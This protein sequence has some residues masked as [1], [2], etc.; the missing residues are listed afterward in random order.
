MIP[1]NFLQHF[2]LNYIEHSYS[3]LVENLYVHKTKT[4]DAIP[5]K[6]KCGRPP[7]PKPEIPIG[8]TR[9]A[10]LQRLQLYEPNNILEV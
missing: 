8:K 1:L 3:H 5:V 2:T 7:K 9:T 10:Q 6:R 4:L